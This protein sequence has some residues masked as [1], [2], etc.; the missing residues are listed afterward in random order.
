MPFGAAQGGFAAAPQ[1]PSF[2]FGA[3]PTGFGAGIAQQ[4]QS[5][6]LGGIDPSVGGGGG[7]FTMGA[8]GAAD[9]GGAGRRRLKAKRQG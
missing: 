5:A 7:G 9:A 3:A 4:Q 8:A 6:P 2:P 1:Q